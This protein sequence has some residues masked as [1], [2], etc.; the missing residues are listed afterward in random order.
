MES[1]LGTWQILNLTKETQEATGP[2]YQKICISEFECKEH[3]NSLSTLGLKRKADQE[4]K[5]EE[6]KLKEQKEK[7]DAELDGE[8][9]DEEGEDECQEEDD[10]EEC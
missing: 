10:E 7:E 9:W 8:E 5:A 3:V 1:E 2:S 6:K 4:K